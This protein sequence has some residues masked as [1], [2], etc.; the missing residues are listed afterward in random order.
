M[1]KMLF[2]LIG[3]S[4]SI[5]VKIILKCYMNKHRKE[6]VKMNVYR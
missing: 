5:S 4:K 3:E 1:K 6:T 2:T